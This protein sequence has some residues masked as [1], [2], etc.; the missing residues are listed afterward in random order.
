MNTAISIDQE[1]NKYLPLLNAR[2][3][4]GT[5]RRKNFCRR[6]KRLVGCYQPRAA[7]GY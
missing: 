4:K 7:T 1:L 5:D 6:T 2:Q 3:K